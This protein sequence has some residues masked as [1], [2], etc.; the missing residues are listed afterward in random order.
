MLLLFAS[1]PFFP[2]GFDSP[3]TVLG[4][5]MY[6]FASPLTS[7]STTVVLASLKKGMAGVIVSIETVSRSETTGDVGAPPRESVEIMAVPD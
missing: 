2:R 6:V 7:A 1:S 5:M 4:A 3:Q